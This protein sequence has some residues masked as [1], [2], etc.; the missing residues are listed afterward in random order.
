M[1]TFNENVPI[2]FADIISLPF[3]HQYIHYSFYQF[4]L[5]VSVTYNSSLL[6]VFQIGTLDGAG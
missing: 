2:N 4:A 5:T 1:L 3:L 6:L